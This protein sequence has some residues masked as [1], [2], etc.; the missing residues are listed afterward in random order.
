MVHG[1]QVGVCR[2]CGDLTTVT[3]NASCMQCGGVYHLALRQDVPEKDC[4]Q[5]WINEESQTLE[6]ACDI[7]LGQ[8]DFGPAAPPSAD[9]PRYARAQGTRAADVVRAKRR[10]RAT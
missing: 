2:V 1:P 6:F 10:R 3:S 5:V 9:R 7:C 8:A 4:G